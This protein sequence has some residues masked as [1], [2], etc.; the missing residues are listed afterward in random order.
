VRRFLLLC[1]LLL[2]VCAWQLPAQTRAPDLPANSRPFDFYNR[3]PYRSDLP[4]PSEFFG[5]ETGDFLTTF[6]LYE[7]LLREYQK[8]S[9]RLRVFTIG[10]T[11]EHRS[12]YILAISSPSNLAR[13]NEIKDQLG[14]LIDPRKLRAGPELDQLIQK[15]PIVVW[16]SYSIHGSESAAFEAG[17]Q[18]LYQLVASNDPALRDALDHTLIL[19]NPCQNPDGH[20]RFATWYNAHGAG[21]QEQ[22]AYEHQ[23]PWS[24]TG[25]LNHNFFDLNRD[26]ISLSQPE[27]EAATRA[28]LEWHPQVLAD[29]HGQTKAYF[30][31]PPALPIN[32]NL[33]E[34]ITIKWLETFGKSNASAFDKYAWPYFVRE[35]FDLFYPGY[36]DSWSSLHGATGMTYE[37]D[38]G[39]PLGYKWRREDGTLLT[40][41][42][43]IA[44]HVTASLATVLVAAANREARLRDYR[45]FFE[46]TLRELKR[47]FYLVPGK[48]PQDATEL[49]S[50]LMKQGIEVS[51]TNA[52]LKL[53]KATNYFGDAPGEKTIP[54]GSF[55]VDTAQPY[56]RMATA[57]LETE[58]PEDSEFLKRQEALRK[59]NEAKGSE[60]AK[61][62]YEFYDVTAWSLP[63]AMGVE[64]YSSDEPIRADMK[65]VA[66]A[67]K[68]NLAVGSAQQAPTDSSTTSRIE[69]GVAYVFEPSSIRAMR[70]AIYLLQ[71]GYR[72]DTSNEAFRAE[73]KEM[74]R[75]TF[76]L[77]AERNPSNLQE[78]LTDLSE[79]YEVT[80]QSIHSSFSDSNHRGIASEASFSLK[81]PKI[82]ILADEPVEQTSYG[83]FLF[84]LEQ[85][86]G[87]DV[88]PV[89][90]E[91]L[92]PDV[93]GQINVLILPD[94][95]ASRYKK[96][97][98]ET[99]L[100][101]L[102]EW[103]SHG[104]V[105]VCIGGA[106]EFAAD[107]DTK[108]TPSRTV[109]SEDRP[110]SSTD[111]PPAETR[112]KSDHSAPQKKESSNPKPIDV[113]GSIV[114]AK[115]NRNHFLT[116]GYDSDTL[117]LL[118]QGDIFLKPSET[119][120]NVLTFEGDKLRISGFFWEGNTEQLLR[121][122]AALIDEPV[123]A[124]NVILFNFEPGFRMI[125]S[126][127]VR[128]LL[129]AI[130]Y[131]P[132]Q[133]PKSDD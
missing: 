29:H 42:E 52:D 124:G 93:L 118:I 27:S 47:K 80:V 30:F 85:K 103:V 43:G 112:Q 9:D 5:Y 87:L 102:R 20:E 92:T 95:Q 91:N 86:C 114:K 19:I 48:D 6:A 72:L 10:K 40:L 37:T 45:D 73:G 121:G 68:P 94:G 75:G 46:T 113:P 71:Q 69:P 41:R 128:L 15:L 98:E 31:P 107:P 74:P 34:K 115:V 133:T 117:P 32:P 1:P 109:G 83:L 97:F 129:N 111:K 14:S 132:S 101:D 23:E 99:Q 55:V 17:I 116:I 58:T 50:L 100:G 2:F 38:G 39:G 22:Y 106:S 125:W 63:L 4:R 78:I 126:S 33:P 81:A 119:G 57:L 26:L 127:T 76:I 77:W 66:A 18:V 67:S 3:G 53:L 70:M 84:L 110:D 8:R 59:A 90:L 82:A 88:V 61:Q 16:L 122:S 123:D 64:A 51:R 79:K 131:G 21:R 12:Q 60:E 24:I 56:G 130:V 54:A 65:A 49:V 44:K 28:L 13:L 11:P 89:S 104:G 108:L 120:A 36:W 35:R 25:R 62:D 96:V 105:L 7:S